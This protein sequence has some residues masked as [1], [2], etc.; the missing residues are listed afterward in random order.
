MAENNS[1]NYLM[2]G[3]VAIVLVVSVVQAFQIN[4]ITNE[5]KPGNATGNIALSSND[6]AG[7]TYE[8]MMARM[9]PELAQ[10]AAQATQPSSSG[11]MVGGC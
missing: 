5:L 10:Q 9:H 1:A 3:M 4:S 8:Q 6:S 11:Q 7:E 2:L